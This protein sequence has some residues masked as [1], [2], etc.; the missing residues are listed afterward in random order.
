M[1]PRPFF[2]LRP[3]TDAP[4]RGR[5]L[6]CISCGLYRDV[7]SPKMQPHG[8]NRRR[9]MVVGEGPGE[10]EDERGKPWQ[11]KA[12][13]FLQDALRDLGIDLA[14]DC[15]S[16]NSVNC[17]PPSNRTPTGY[18]VAC[19]RHKI[20]SP[21]I[22]R[23][24]P[25]VILLMGG[26]AVTS[27]LGQ[28]HSGALDA[29]IGKWR[30]FCIPVPEWGAWVCPTY[31]PSY[32]LREERN[33]QVDT[34]WRRDIRRAI[35]L[36]DAQSPAPDDLGRLVNIPRAEVNVLRAI[37]AAHEAKW[38]SFDYETTGLRASLHDVVC[39]SFATSPDRVVAF[40]MP[41][42]G[43]I[44]GAWAKLLSDPNVGKISHNMKFED[45]WSRE[46]FDV[47]KIEWAWDSM[48]AAHVVDNRVGICGLKFQAF[49]TFGIRSWDDE[50]EPY[51]KAIDAGDPRS[52]NRIWEFVSRYGEDACLT[53]C[54]LDSLIAY[55]LAM[56]QMEA[57]G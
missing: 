43:P 42:T 17:R 1:P 51:L 10:T 15:V 49:L 27:V 31:H 9:V 26:S 47:E 36:L 21:A 45:A 8:E 50:I 6:S 7:L 5:Q 14:R 55:R 13:R 30:G 3:E 33:S 16:A 32:V 57:I 18:E 40:M 37:Y 54:G 34:V 28:L 35:G 44:P 2:V 52:P 38:L 22:A 20:V 4:E 24:S 25:K 48:I 29:P 12:G 39:A 23:Y 53:Y 41:E 19:C 46:H 11:G 56:R